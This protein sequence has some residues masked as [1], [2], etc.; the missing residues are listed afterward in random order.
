[1][2]P[3][4]TLRKGNIQQTFKQAASLKEPPVLTFRKEDLKHKNMDVPVMRP[5]PLIYSYADMDVGWP[6]TPRIGITLG[7]T[8]M[9]FLFQFSTQEVSCT[10]CCCTIAS[11]NN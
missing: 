2:P 8:R 3:W 7:N 1:M 4:E 10:I 6:E 9:L 5:T 11:V